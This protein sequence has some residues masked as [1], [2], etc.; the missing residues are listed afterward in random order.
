MKNLRTNHKI[1][2][3]IIGIVV[4]TALSNINL[5]SQCCKTGAKGDHSKCKMNTTDTANKVDSTLI[6]TGV[7]DV[8]EIDSNKDGF[9]Y[10]C[11]MHWN[12]I[13]DNTASC[14]ICSMDLEKY[15]V[16]DAILNLKNNKF[17]VK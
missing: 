6:R 12:V 11:P 9:V 16:K 14:P 4:I 15:K 17:E 8:Y 7:I 2:S 5:N 10:Q 3:I 13:S 1:I